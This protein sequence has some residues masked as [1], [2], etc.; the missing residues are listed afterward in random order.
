MT[1][2]R[3]PQ[4]DEVEK[5]YAISDLL[6]HS[7]L[8][9]DSPAL[10]IDAVASLKI[11]ARACEGAISSCTPGFG[12]YFRRYIASDAVVRIFI[13]AF[14]YCF[15]ALFE[16]E[17]TRE[18]HNTVLKMRMAKAFT[19]F[20]WGLKHGKK[21]DF[22]LQYFPYAL[23]AAI[24]LTFKQT[25]PGSA[26]QLEP[27]DEFSDYLNA[28]IS[29]LFVHESGSAHGQALRKLA[30]ICPPATAIRCYDAHT[31]SMVASVCRCARSY[32]RAGAGG[33]G[34]R[35]MAWRCEACGRAGSSHARGG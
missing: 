8:D 17:G 3:K 33:R 27:S 14:W 28:V 11:V 22:F 4:V 6:Q 21:K 19:T 13:D 26:S 23:V 1:K 24:H 20:C 31:Q 10:D 2:W 7:P 9:A 29:E 35:P 12:K 32:S 15:V 34:C 30:R 5:D 25:F 18:Q 16:S